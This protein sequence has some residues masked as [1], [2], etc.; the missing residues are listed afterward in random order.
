M[1]HRLARV[2]GWASLPAALWTATLLLQHHAE[3][4]RVMEAVLGLHHGDPE[5]AVALTAAVVL[6][7]L[8]AW[9]AS[10]GALLAFVVHER[11]RSPRAPDGT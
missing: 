8:V 5:R 4:S 7:R 10:G 6:L 1:S 2:L 3:R 11:L 9:S